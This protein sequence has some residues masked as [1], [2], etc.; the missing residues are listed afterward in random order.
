MRGFVLAVLLGLGLSPYMLMG[1]EGVSANMDESKASAQELGEVEP[2]PR[3]ELKIDDTKE[4]GSPRLGHHLMFKGYYQQALVHLTVH[5]L[6]PNSGQDTYSTP[7][8]YYALGVFYSYYLPLWN[9]ISYFVG[10]GVEWNVVTDMKGAKVLTL[11]RSY[12]LPSFRL[13]IQSSISAFH[14]L[15]L[16]AEYALKQIKNLKQRHSEDFIEADFYAE[17]IEIGIQWL[18]YM[19]YSW[20]LSVSLVWERLAY[21]PSFSG[22]RRNFRFFQS[23]LRGGLGVLMQL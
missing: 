21:Q 18:A 6:S 19:D 4:P 3:Y 14:D 5:R 10:T 22:A 2:E 7:V 12:N 11:G 23:S 8:D 13:G 16:V 15:R 17:D 1:K 20:A 9:E